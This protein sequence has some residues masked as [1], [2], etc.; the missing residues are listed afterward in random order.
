MKESV[1]RGRGVWTALPY[2]LTSLLFVIL[3]TAILVLNHG[4]FVY[5]LDDAYVHL[6]LSE[7]LAQFHYGVNAGE[8]S[9]PSSSILW[10]FLFAWAAPWAFH[11]YLPLLVNVVATFAALFVLLRRLAPIGSA[12]GP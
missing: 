8:V 10:P 3:L 2:G 4:R 11:E 12:A 1:S 9:S 7:G 6:A 5:T